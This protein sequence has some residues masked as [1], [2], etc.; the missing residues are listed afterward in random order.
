MRSKSLSLSHALQNCLHY[1]ELNILHFILSSHT[2][3]F[4]DC[5][6]QIITTKLKYLRITIHYSEITFLTPIHYSEIT[7]IDSNCLHYYECHL[8]IKT[9]SVKTNIITFT[10]SVKT[11]IITFK[12]DLFI[13]Y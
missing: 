2:A 4:I 7:L 11:N 8:I 6:Y 5:N 1:V 9:T 12:T 10:K 3:T 13:P